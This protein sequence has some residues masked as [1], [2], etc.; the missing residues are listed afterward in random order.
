MENVPSARN[1]LLQNYSMM[2]N[3]ELLAKHAKQLVD[4][5]SEKTENVKSAQTTAKSEKIE[6]RVRSFHALETRSLQ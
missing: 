6:D 3:A 1:S 5:S 4:N 2:T